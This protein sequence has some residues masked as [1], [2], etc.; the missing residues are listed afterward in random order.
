MDDLKPWKRLGS[1][2]L[3]QHDRVL[4]REDRIRLPEGG[5]RRY[6]VMQLGQSA[7]IVPLT[8]DGQ[9]ILI[10]Q[11]RHVTGGFCWEIP[12]GRVE[13]GE[14]PQ[15]A[16]I[17]ECL[18]ETGV[19]CRNLRVLA[20]YHPGLDTFCNPTYLYA[21]DDISEGAS[22]TAPQG[23]TVEMAWFSLH[24]A[25]GMI[26]SLQIVDAFTMIG[27]LTYSLGGAARRR[28]VVPSPER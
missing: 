28:S 23:E 20:G 24:E 9:V 18:E 25:L 6:P 8:A 26:S 11:Y 22:P 14:T 10:R 13:E 3:H 4:I 19:A 12:G 5:E 7:G 21:S 17:R 15:Q 1:R 2:T 27:V 16:A